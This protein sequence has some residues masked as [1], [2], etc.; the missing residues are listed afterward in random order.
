MNENI[1]NNSNMLKYYK[2]NILGPPLYQIEQLLDLRKLQNKYEPVSSNKQIRTIIKYSKNYI[3]KEMRSKLIDLFLK[4][5]NIN[6]SYEIVSNMLTLP[7]TDITFYRIIGDIIKKE[8]KYK[9]EKLLNTI[10]HRDKKVEMF[11]NVINN[12]K[13]FRVTQ[14]LDY[15]CGDCD[16]TGKCGKALN[17]DTKNIFGADI[18]TWGGYNDKTRNIDK[19]NFVNIVPNKPLAFDD[20]TFDL[21]SCFMVLHHIENLEFCLQELNR[22][23]KSGGYLYITEHM[24]TNFMEK[25]LVDIEHSIYEIAY[26]NTDDYHLS[27]IN[28][29]YHWTEWIVIMD[30]YNFQYISHNNLNYDILEQNDPT[31]KAWLLFKKID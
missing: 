9:S 31:K 30:K 26:R 10:S 29:F 22:I 11:I 4:H 18:N 7:L 13:D 24:V 14:Y 23:M 28:K 8:E 21:I 15:G 6:N 3:F 2:N 27:Y 12:I 17:L 16:V 1:L 19:I 20:K 5:I 25:M